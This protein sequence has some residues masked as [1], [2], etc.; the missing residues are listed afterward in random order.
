VAG[1]TL[2]TAVAYGAQADELVVDVAL[3]ES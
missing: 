2:A 1:E 3:A